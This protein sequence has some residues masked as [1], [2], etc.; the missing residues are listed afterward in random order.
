[1][2]RKKKL[3]GPEVRPDGV[4]VGSACMTPG[5][6]LDPEEWLVPFTSLQ[7]VRSA[8]RALVDSL[9]KCASDECQDPAT[10]FLPYGEGFCVHHEHEAEFH[11][12]ASNYAEPLRKLQALLGGKS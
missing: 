2:S 7:A 6:S 1:M 5:G 10:M 3:A 4:P 12:R 11:T 8:A 9:A